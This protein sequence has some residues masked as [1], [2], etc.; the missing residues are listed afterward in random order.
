MSQKK[1]HHPVVTTA[2][3]TYDLLF[4]QYQDSNPQA[5]TYAKL[6]HLLV[7]KARVYALP[8]NGYV[9]QGPAPD[10][11]YQSDQWSRLPE[12]IVFLHYDIKTEEHA[13]HEPMSQRMII[14]FDLHGEF[15]PPGFQQAVQQTHDDLQRYGAIGLVSMA[16]AAGSDHESCSVLPLAGMVAK[17]SGPELPSLHMVSIFHD[18]A[19][20]TV[21]QFGKEAFL[22]DTSADLQFA[23]LNLSRWLMALTPTAAS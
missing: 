18:K 4:Q 7:S 22:C 21:D 3:S 9:S 2:L 10:A 14:A 19:Q 15:I 1:K 16:Q 5:Q 8:T 17:K 12:P 6:L 23:L 11:F 13:Q 20:Q